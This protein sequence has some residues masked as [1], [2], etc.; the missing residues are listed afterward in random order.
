M[1]N[2]MTITIIK[3]I[4]AI[5]CT[6]ESLKSIPDVVTQSARITINNVT[7]VI[8]NPFQY[9]NHPLFT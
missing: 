4:L 2:Q 9:Y 5:F 1:I 6:L 8:K 7:D 3:I